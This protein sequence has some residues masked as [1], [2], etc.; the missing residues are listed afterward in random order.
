MA[1]ERLALYAGG[2]LGGRKAKS[3]ETHLAA[4]PDCRAELEEYRSVLD[5][6]RAWASAPAPADWTEPEWG[7]MIAAITTG[8]DEKAG[9]RGFRVLSLKPAM[10]AAAFLVVVLGTQYALR[11]MLR[12]GEVSVSTAATPSII[13]RPGAFPGRDLRAAVEFA[14]LREARP[15]SPAPLKRDFPVLTWKAPE[16]G[17]TIVWFF[18]DNLKLEE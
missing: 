5:D 8:P 1:R 11:W 12:T 13:E 14:G 9:R 2:D 10:A 3:V 16:T 17:V 18:N 15:E 4:C 6:A 7:R